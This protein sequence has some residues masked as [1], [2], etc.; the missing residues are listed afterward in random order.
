MVCRGEP[1]GQIRPSQLN[2]CEMQR[3]ERRPC[4]LFSGAGVSFVRGSSAAG[5]GVTR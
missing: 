3:P 4:A 1:A 2:S 5:E